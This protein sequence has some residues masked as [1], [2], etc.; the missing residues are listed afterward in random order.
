MKTR[1]SP[2]STVPMASP[3]SLKES[4]TA[5][6]L[7]NRSLFMNGISSN[8]KRTSDP[9]TMSPSR[10]TLTSV[11]DLKDLL[12][13]R[14]DDLRRNLIDRSHT[15][16]LKDV[17]AS[18]SRLHKRLKIQIKASQQVM[19]ETEKEYKKINERISETQ[20]A[21]KVSYA[22]F[23]SEAQIAASRVCKTSITELSKS[24][25]REIDGLRKRFG[26]S[27]T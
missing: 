18:D 19:D 24:F 3:F 7:D 10:K 26:T 5:G 1:G 22:E 4:P 20:E 6:A 8:K 27:A 21:I 9:S 23:M 12:S 15:E 2:K 11:S 17:E 14:L 16:I 25:E 13:S